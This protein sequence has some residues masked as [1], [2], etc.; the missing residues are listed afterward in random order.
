MRRV[1]VAFHLRPRAGEVE[2]HF[3]AAAVRRHGDVQLERDVGGAHAVVVHDV[4]EGVFARRNAGQR[5][6]QA[7]A[8]AADDL[9]EGRFEQ[10]DAARR[11]HL[12]HAPHTETAGRD[13]RKIIAAPLLRHTRVEQQ[14]VHHVVEQ[15]AAAEQPDHR[16]AR[17]FLIDLGA[18]GHAARR[19]AADVGMVRDVAHEADELA[20]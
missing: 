7:F 5:F 20:S 10:R 18:A 12:A 1:D 14:Q 11:D 17:A 6:A 4:F 16:D 3:P 9:V 19:D 8:R 15:F 2:Q 13:L